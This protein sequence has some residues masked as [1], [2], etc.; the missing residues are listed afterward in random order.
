MHQFTVRFDEDLYRAL[1]AVALAEGRTL[2][3]I[4]RTSVRDYTQST[5]DIDEIKDLIAKARSMGSATEEKSLEAAK[6]AAA[7]DD[8][9]GLDGIVITRTGG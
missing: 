4:I 3:E 8:Q 5:P 2:A 9:E 7:A 1:Q 6:R